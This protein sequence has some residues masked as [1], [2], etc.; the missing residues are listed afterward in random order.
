MENNNIKKI[1]MSDGTTLDLDI[2]NT[3]L[4]LNEYQKQWTKK[5][6][7]HKMIKKGLNFFF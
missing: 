6:L 7:Y 3:V 2:S 1:I 4:V 5:S